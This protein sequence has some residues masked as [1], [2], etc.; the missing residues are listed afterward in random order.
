MTN[1]ELLAIAAAKSNAHGGLIDALEE[2]RISARRINGVDYVYARHEGETF[3][4][5]FDSSGRVH[6]RG[7]VTNS[8]ARDLARDALLAARDGR[9]RL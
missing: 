4:M 1:A 2:G 3:E 6:C 7:F 5:H 8:T 9:T